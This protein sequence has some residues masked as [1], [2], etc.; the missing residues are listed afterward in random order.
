MYVHKCEVYIMCMY[1][2]GIFIEGPRNVTYLPG[3]T[4]LPIELTCNIIG[5]PIWE[6]NGTNYR[7]DELDDGEL[8]GHSRTGS[9]ILVNSPI[10]NTEYICVSQAINGSYFSD[11]A[12]VVVAG[13]CSMHTLM[14]T[15]I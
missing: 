10:N 2:A 8:L 14:C 5:F 7:L 1:C 11:P 13:K 12:Y 15:C 9:N 4:P 6:V 3:L